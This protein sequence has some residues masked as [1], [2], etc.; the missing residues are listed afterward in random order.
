MKTELFD[1]YPGAKK[2]HQYTVKGLL[3]LAESYAQKQ[4]EEEADLIEYYRQFR[5]MSRLLKNEKKV[6]TAE[7][8]YYFWTTVPDMQLALRMGQEVFSDNVLGMESDDPIAEMFTKPK[9]KKKMRMEVNRVLAPRMRHISEA[10]E[11]DREAGDNIKDLVKQLRALHVH[12]VSYAGVYAKLV[13]IL[14]VVASATAALPPISQTAQTAAIPAIQMTPYPN[15]PT[16]PVTYPKHQRDNQLQCFGHAGFLECQAIM[17]AVTVEAESEE[18]VEASLSRVQRQAME[19]IDVDA[20]EDSED[21]EGDDDSENVDGGDTWMGLLE[22]ER[23]EENAG[24]AVTRL[25]GR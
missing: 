12:D 11:E 20:L 3:K 25:A 9:E 22:L 2:G 1:A 23:L 21:S 16:N 6:T 5:I 17:G 13:A 8:D 10:K 18:E 14:P 7:I 24:M 4:I 19:I 15:P